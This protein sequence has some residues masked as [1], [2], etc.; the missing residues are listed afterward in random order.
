MSFLSV[1]ALGLLHLVGLILGKSTYLSMDRV[2]GIPMILEVMGGKLQVFEKQEEV[3]QES[4]LKES[5]SVTNNLVYRI[6]TLKVYLLL[7]SQ[8]AQVALILGMQC[9]LSMVPDISSNYQSRFYLVTLLCVNTLFL[10]H[11]LLSL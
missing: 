2:K 10:L 3:M 7:T 4:L 6:I 9:Y 1:F 8:L 11:L 5:V